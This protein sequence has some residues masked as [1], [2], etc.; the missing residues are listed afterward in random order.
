MIVHNGDLCGAVLG[1][2]KDYS[3][4]VIDANGVE[5]FEIALEGFQA[6]ARRDFHIVQI[7]CLVQLNK[8]A[9]GHP[10]NGVEA[11][12]LLVTK[13]FFGVGVLEGL[14][15]LARK[16]GIFSTPVRKVESS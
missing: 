10:R 15:H 1:P 13:E 6:I 4:L 9:K 3:P 16:L 7:S 11:A 5:G 2:T 8:L 14:N 12:A